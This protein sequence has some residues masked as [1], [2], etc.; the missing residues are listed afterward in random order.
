MTS[1]D[2]MA[3]GARKRI[4]PPKPIAIWDTRELLVVATP[5]VMLIAVVLWFLL[6]LV[7]PA[8]PS[9]IT[10]ATGGTEGA[11]YSF[12]KAYAEVLARSGIT[13]RVRA[14]SGSIE[15]LRLLSDPASGVD[16][17]LMQ[18]GIISATSGKDVVS[19]GR[20]FVEPLWVFYRADRPIEMLHEL[21]GRRIGIG[22]DG[23]GT[24]Q[25]ALTLLQ[26]N[27]LRRDSANLSPLTGEA[28][29]DALRA[30]TLDA[31]FLAMAPE[32]PVIQALVQDPTIKLMNFAQAEA[33]TRYLPYLKRI[34]LPRGAFN[35]ARDVPGHD[36]S[37]IAP[38]AAVVARDGFHSA[39][40]G[41]L[42][43][44]MREVHGKGGLFSRFGEFPQAADP[45]V[46]L[47]PDV[48]RYYKAG[49]SFLK[50][51]LPF[52]LATMLE[53]MLV[54]AVPVAGL[55]IPM[56]RL[57]PLIYKWRIKRRLLYWYARLKALESQ[58]LADPQGGALS[59][60]RS[61]IERID[62]AIS[63]IP[64]PLG[65]SEEYYN[66]RRAVDLVRQRILAH[67]TFIHPNL[68]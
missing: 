28:A 21:K 36:T 7:H 33:Y 45:E 42:I 32:S 4:L 39:L 11:Y 1:P 6:K 52:W 47:A 8:P 18:G 17:A 31:V 24:R 38:V 62:S 54:L 34:V 43:D 48:E 29:A 16:V 35:L 40:A 10:I 41:L 58:L 37:L 13:L 56:A 60:Q 50:R 27:G 30:G 57:L 12:G 14:T 26:T 49:P 5:A 44:A 19:L 59:F 63:N 55:I 9:V 2:S 53:R 20:A 22:P 46:D 15:N 66:L 51:F 25:L 23:S 65:F 64:V 67:A 3:R 68:T 61:E